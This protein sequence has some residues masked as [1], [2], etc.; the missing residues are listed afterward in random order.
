ML[1]LLEKEISKLNL[2]EGNLPEIVLA[3]ADSIPTHNIP[4]RMKIALAI[5]EIMLFASHFRIKIKHWNN[6]LIPV[7]S[8]MFCIAKSGMSKDSSLRAVRKCFSDGY[9][10]INKIRHD[11]AI[12]K[13]IKEATDAGADL[14]DRF[15][16]Y[17]DYYI[18]PNPLFLAISTTE[19]FVQH[20]NDL[21][22][23]ELGAGFIYSG[24]FGAELASNSNLTDNI[25]ILAELYDEGNKEVKVLK[26][27]E[28]QSKEIKNFPTSALFIGSQ[29]NLLYDES[30]KHKFKTEFTTKL[31]RRSFFIFINED[32][33]PTS[34]PS[35][36]AMLEAERKLEDNALQ[37][38]LD[39]KEYIKELTPDLIQRRNTLVTVDEDVRDLFTLYKKY[40][41]ELSST[42]DSQI[43]ITKLTRA[44]LQWKALKLA[45]ALAIIQQ[46]NSIDIDHYKAAIEFVELINDDIYNF[47]NELTKEPYELFVDYVKSYMINGEY[48]MGLHALKKA[49]F[50]PAKGL[51]DTHLKELTKLANACDTDG[52]YTLSKDTI[53]YNALTKKDTILVSYV[54]CT[55]TKEQ[56]R[57]KCAKGYTCIETTFDKLQ[58]LLEDDYAFTPF[59]FKNGIRNKDNII[60]GCKWLVL[61]VDDSEITDEECHL[62]LSDLNHFI[63]RTSNK[64]N[65][66]KYRVLIE[67]DTEINVPDTQWTR[68]I[69]NIGK[70]LGLKCDLVPKSQIYFSY[71]DR[72]ILSILNENTLHIKPYLDLVNNL[73]K[74]VRV[75][76]TNKKTCNALL[77]DPLT[78]F[79]QAF[80]ARDGE[81]RRKLIWSVKY[82]RDLGADKEYCKNL[83]DQISD[84]WVKPL[85]EKDLEIIKKQLDRWEF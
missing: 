73:E 13:A 35:I 63:V 39:V 70:D 55:G 82:A 77:D 31:A 9:E 67:L 5:S 58:E 64:D 81:G 76:P 48:S 23:D 4:Y 22:N 36:Q 37:N 56:R 61:D 66:N 59:K 74:N 80:E 7:N 75:I 26:S 72:N 50:I 83:L 32:I 69:D 29:D 79:N 71:S 28:N 21:A 51:S 38:Y 12:E 8:I 65:A 14:P 46:C 34:Y 2:F 10:I 15:I 52:I 49:G 27:R 33:I 41:E 60:S 78:T 19:G 44:H 3:I 43:P 57:T 30:I 62:M 11:T 40:N 85:P 16:G 6:S 17:K 42:I 47:E 20:L 84:Y 24:E 25:K 45:G 1:D 53:H 18:P 54:P 68:L